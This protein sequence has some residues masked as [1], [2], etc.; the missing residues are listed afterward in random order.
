MSAASVRSFKSRASR[1]IVIFVGCLVSL[2]CTAALGDEGYTIC[3]GDRASCQSG[4]WFSCGTS[5]NQAAQAV[6]TTSTAAG[7]TVSNFT[8]SRIYS[9]P[10]GQCGSSGF[11]ITCK[12]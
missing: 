10:G 5:A 3:I 7:Q 6:C 4:A 9:K 12:K 2:S 1:S 11:V 8:I